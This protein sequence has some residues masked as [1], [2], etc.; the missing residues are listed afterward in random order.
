MDLFVCMPIRCLI[1]F[2]WFG[3]FWFECVCVCVFFFFISGILFVV[4]RFSCNKSLQLTAYHRCHKECCRGLTGENR[5]L[6]ETFSQGT[7]SH[8]NRGKAKC[9]KNNVLDLIN[10]IR[11]DSFSCSLCSFFAVANVIL[12]STHLIPK[13]K[14]HNHH[15]YCAGFVYVFALSS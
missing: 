13:Q 10:Y 12:A 1:N 6:N 2:A 3:G 5:V 11:F 14:L 7:H 8:T 9:I 4:S 15:C